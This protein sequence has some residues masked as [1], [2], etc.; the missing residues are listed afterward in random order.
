ME[1]TADGI[2]Q[3]QDITTDASPA[4]TEQSAAE[5]TFTQNELDKI[6]GRVRSETR[7]EAYN[8][9]KSELEA[10]RQSNPQSSSMGGME[11][12]SPDKINEMIENKLHERVRQAEAHRTATDFVNKIKSAETNYPGLEEKVMKLNLAAAPHIYEWAN[13]H[14]NTADIMNEFVQNPNKYAEIIVLSSFATDAAREMMDRLSKS[15][16]KNHEAL[17]QPSADEPLSQIKPS[18]SVST[19][20]GSMTVRDLKRQAWLRG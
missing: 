2:S 19:D 5:K 15:I 4:A 3:G 12:V 18:S 13:S 9:A 16:K 17:K 11:Q 8:R 6:V 10:Q 7:Q 20:N 14:D 1:Q